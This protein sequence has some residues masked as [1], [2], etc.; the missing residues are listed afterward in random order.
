[1]A[2]RFCAA[3]LP[4]RRR[5]QSEQGE[6]ASERIA[7]DA[8]RHLRGAEGTGHDAD[9][10]DFDDEDIYEDE[11]DEDE[12]ALLD[13]HEENEDEDLE[14][15]SLSVLEKQES[16]EQARLRQQALASYEDVILS[17]RNADAHGQELS[18]QDSFNRRAT[19]SPLQLDRRNSGEDLEQRTAKANAARDLFFLAQEGDASAALELRRGDRAPSSASWSHRRS[20]RRRSAGGRHE[21]AET[22][23]SFNY[24]LM[25]RAIEA[26]LRELSLRATEGLSQQERVAADHEREAI[27][28]MSRQFLGDQADMLRTA[29]RECKRLAP[30]LRQHMS[31]VAKELNRKL[32]ENL[33][34]GAGRRGAASNGFAADDQE[35]YET[36]V[37]KLKKELAIL[38]RHLSQIRVEQHFPRCMMWKLKVDAGDGTF[39]G[40]RDLEIGEIKAD[41]HISTVKSKPGHIRMEVNNIVANL[42]IQE[43]SIR[44]ANT[45][46]RILGGLLTPTIT[47]LDLDV[48]GSWILEL[49]F[50]QGSGHRQH[51]QRDQRAGQQSPQARWEEVKER[52]TFNLTLTRK[53][54]GLTTIRLPQSFLQTLSKL[55]IPKLVTGAIKTI[56]PIEL[57][58]LLREHDNAVSVKGSINIAGD[59]SP[60]TWREPLVGPTA[61]AARARASLGI[62]QSEA[63]MLDYIC[64]GSRAAAAGFKNKAISLGRLFKWRLKY[65]TYRVDELQEMLDLIQRD[66]SA[67]LPRGWLAQLVL[68]VTLLAKKPLNVRLAL[69]SVDMDINLSRTVDAALD[70]YMTYFAQSVAGARAQKARIAARQHFEEAQQRVAAIRKLMRDF[71]TPL[72]EPRVEGNITGLFMGGINA[73]LSALTLRNVIAS[74]RMPAHFLFRPIIP[75]N[76]EELTIE[77]EGLAGPRDGEYTV[78]LRMDDLDGEAS[79]TLRDVHL[80]LFR[81]GSEPGAIVFEA[82]EARASMMLKMLDQI[83]YAASQQVQVSDGIDADAVGQD[84]GAFVLAGTAPLVERVEAILSISRAFDADTGGAREDA[85]SEAAHDDADEARETKAT[86]LPDF[87]LNDANDL[88][89]DVSDIHVVIVKENDSRR[90]REKVLRLQL[91]AQ[92][93]KALQISIRANMRD[94]LDLYQ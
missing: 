33:G 28:V 5:G 85:P 52:S 88:R 81:A 93:E 37:S 25:E 32:C 4:G 65:A 53:V 35:Q 8:A 74:L 63:I 91:H 47:R 72:V 55:L 68:F 59:M 22:P 51:R 67:T 6:L 46:A 14:D 50:S 30:Q 1:M 62:S 44:G 77:I 48:R 76:L 13:S 3:L 60:Q 49:K 7:H 11:V 90:A 31:T 29:R 73:G 57:G 10:D 80:D 16:G 12:D 41:Y 69:T 34:H 78:K 82:T 20:Q 71:V 27:E 58:L 45:K 40:M 38:T 64:R 18:F 26:S 9:L 39:I 92:S 70:A 36:A 87:V 94:M 66:A 21:G 54:T 17:G 89:A 42:G 23:D 83:L 61:A 24:V 15:E 56:L 43:L 79:L 75:R 19:A 86:F 2:S 84:P